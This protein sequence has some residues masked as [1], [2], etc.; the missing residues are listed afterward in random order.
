MVLRSMENH[1][2]A[3]LIVSELLGRSSGLLVDFGLETTYFVQLE[4]RQKLASSIYIRSRY[5][6]KQFQLV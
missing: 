2:Q 5:F 1:S 6:R 3:K 4:L